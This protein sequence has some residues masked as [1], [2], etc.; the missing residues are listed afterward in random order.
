M[1]YYYSISEVSEKTSVKTHV[2]RYWE[3]EFKQLRPKKSKTGRRTY[4]ENDI[5]LV[6]LISRLLH[7]EHYTIEGVRE[8]LKNGDNKTVV[9]K[10]ILKEIRKGLEELLDILSE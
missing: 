7:E 6:S 4:T 5:S 10:D 2:L 1:K 3:K 8:R 9:D